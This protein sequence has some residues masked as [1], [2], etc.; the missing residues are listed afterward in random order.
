[1]RNHRGWNMISLT[2]YLTSNCSVKYNKLTRHTFHRWSSNRQPFW[3]L[4]LIHS[5]LLFREGLLPQC[6]VDV[7]ISGVVEAVITGCCSKRSTGGRQGGH[8]WLYIRSIAA[9]VMIGRWIRVRM[10]RW[11]RGFTKEERRG[12]SHFQQREDKCGGSGSEKGAKKERKGALII[13]NKGEDKE[14]Q[15]ETV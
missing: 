5:S 6:F 11:Q 9:R 4:V 1:M 7:S 13:E 10:D 12:R 8:S 3:Y 14:K 2:F 15:K